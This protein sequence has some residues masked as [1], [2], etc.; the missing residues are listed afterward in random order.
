MVD[1]GPDPLPDEI[2]GLERIDVDLCAGVAHVAHDAAV[3]QA[4]QVV[5][6]DHALVASRG[7][8]LKWSHC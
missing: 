1:V 3:L 4:L 7:H 5:A 6:G 8:D 2:G